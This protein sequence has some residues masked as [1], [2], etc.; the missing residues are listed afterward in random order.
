LVAPSVT[1]E[2]LARPNN[3]CCTTVGK[4]ECHS[5]WT[6]EAF[7]VHLVVDE[8]ATGIVQRRLATAKS[9]L[10]ALDK[11]GLGNGIERAFNVG[12]YALLFTSI[13]HGRSSGAFVV[14]SRD[15]AS[16]VCGNTSLLILQA[17]LKVS[18][19]SNF[20]EIHCFDAA[21]L[22]F[23]SSSADLVFVLQ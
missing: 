19:Y 7:A 22:F 13:R 6:S 17:N 18:V 11:F 23:E 8:A 5:N 3:F 12:V 14:V 9:F 2:G 1:I 15:S 16:V 21:L 10:G 20:A 4:T